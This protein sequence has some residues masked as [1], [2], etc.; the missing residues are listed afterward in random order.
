MK[1]VPSHSKE[2]SGSNY[3]GDALDLCWRQFNRRF[4]TEKACLKELFRRLIAAG[5]KCHHCNSRD[6]VWYSGIRTIR[7]LSCAEKS[8][9]T[10]GTFFH[11]VRLVRPWLAAIWFIE[12][13]VSVNSSKF[14]KLVGIAYSSALSIF[15]KLMLVV[16]HQM[17]EEA[18]AISSGC[19]AALFCRRS[20]ETPA[21][22]HPSA[23]Q[24]EIE[25]NSRGA[26]DGN[27]IEG[28]LDSAAGRT[29]VCAGS[30]ASCAREDILHSSL[31]AGQSAVEAEGTTTG[32][33]QLG[34]TERQVYESLSDEAI[35][36]DSLCQITGISVGVL[37][38]AL[39]MLELSGLAKSLPGDLY[40]RCGADRQTSSHEDSVPDWAVKTV[41]I[42]ITLIRKNFQG[43]SRKYL[44]NYLAWHWCLTDRIRWRPGALLK[45]C[46]GFRPIRYEDVLSY[47]SPPLVKVSP[48]LSDG[49]QAT[50]I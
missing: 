23:E 13:G 24:E 40:V 38:A 15:K 18:P 5:A 48:A 46:L 14:H 47:V 8:W 29:D 10:A 44:Q 11:G 21:R 42:V 45:E 31:T 20:R 33:S 17:R 34:S 12:H 35:Q 26:K 36:F 2:D 41:D 22:E 49:R 16:H 43:I 7:C 39:M 3:N 37:S 30:G 28:D 1:S 50:N 19:F 6:I 32:E 9:L 27:Q 25:K 4:K